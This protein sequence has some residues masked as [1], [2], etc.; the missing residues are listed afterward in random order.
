MVLIQEKN[1]LNYKI[2][3]YFL[4]RQAIYDDEPTISKP[5]NQRVIGVLSVKTV[6]PIRTAQIN[7]KKSNGSKITSWPL[8]NALFKSVWANVPEIAIKKIIKN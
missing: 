3:F 5:P 1:W 6:Y 7:F 8:L 2:N 4:S